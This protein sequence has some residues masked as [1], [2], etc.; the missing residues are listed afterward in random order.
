MLKRRAVSDARFVIVLAAVTLAFIVIGMAFTISGSDQRNSIM[1]QQAQIQTLEKQLEALNASSGSGGGAFK[2]T[3][4]ITGSSPWNST[5][6]GPRY[7]V[8]TPDGL[9]SSANISLPAHTLIQLA[10]LDYDSATPLPSQYDQVTG[11]V[12]NVVYVVNGTTASGG[13]ANMTTAQAVRSL[14]PNTQVGHTFTVPQIG[15][16]IPVAANSVEVADLYINQTGTFVW[17]CEDPCG[18]GPTG[19]LGPMSTNGWMGGTITVT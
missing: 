6:T 1:T 14:D 19:W 2:L 4:V 15:L 10:I 11:T 5:T 7:W 16:N 3:L 18:F 8:L 12:G 9:E 17:H 13:F